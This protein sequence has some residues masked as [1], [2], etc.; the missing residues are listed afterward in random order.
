[1]LNNHHQEKHHGMRR[2]MSNFQ[3]IITGIWS[4]P[5]ERQSAEGVFISKQLDQRDKR[6]IS[7]LAQPI[8]LNSHKEFNQ[9]GFIREKIC[10]NDYD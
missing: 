3:M 7:G 6:R 1:M 8:I 10:R 4:K 9:P 2:S 5:T